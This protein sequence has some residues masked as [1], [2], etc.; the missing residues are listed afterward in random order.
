MNKKIKNKLVNYKMIGIV[1]L[2]AVMGVGIFGFNR[3][4]NWYKVDAVIGLDVNPSIEIEVSKKE[5]IIGVKVLNDEAKIVLD[6]MD[7]EGVD[8]EVGINAILGSMIKNDYLSVDANSI[9]VSVKSGNKAKEKEL[10]EEISEDIDEFL[11]ANL[12]DS[13]IMM[14]SFDNDDEVLEIATINDISSGKAELISKIIEMEIKNNDGSLYTSDT[15]AKLSINELK[16]LLEEKEVLVKDV[17]TSGI[18]SDSSYIGKDKAK[19]IVFNDSGVLEK[20][21]YDLEIDMDL[22]SGILVYEVDFSVDGIEY[23]YDIEAT[24]GEVVWKKTEKDDDYYEKK[25]DNLDSKSDSSYIGKEKAKE[26]AFNDSGVLEKDVYDLEVELDYDDGSIL[27]EVTFNINKM[28]YEYDI[29][30]VS[31]KIINKRVEFD[32]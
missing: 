24:S 12:I 22:E 6:D 2:C 25:N 23:E 16:L 19:E 15:L 30:A 5:K 17:A 7:L 32:D 1:S 31:G 13:S 28:E 26:I 10:Q 11:K 21:V 4:N 18:A 9:L 14:Q 29:D 8:L 20:D 3:Y 27:Y